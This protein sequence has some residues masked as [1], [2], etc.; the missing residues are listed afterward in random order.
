MVL[1]EASW[2]E[3]RHTVESHRQ[4]RLENSLV[5]EVAEGSSCQIDRLE[6]GLC[7]TSS[8]VSKPYPC[9]T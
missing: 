7:P 3:D 6:D 9:L 8:D 2:P 4:V 5:S 1:L